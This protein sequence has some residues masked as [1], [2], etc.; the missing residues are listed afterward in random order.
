MNNRSD[1]YRMDNLVEL[2]FGLKLKL[3]TIHCVNLVL[4]KLKSKKLESINIF[5][6]NFNQQK[7]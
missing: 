1:S 7:P 5:F 3:K 2:L 6:K 4:K